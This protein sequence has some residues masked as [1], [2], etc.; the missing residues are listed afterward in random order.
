MADMS[1]LGIVS[2][3]G[4]VAL[5][6]LV[7]RALTP[8][9]LTLLAIGSAWGRACRSACCCS[10]ICTSWRCCFGLSLIGIAVDYS[11]YY[12]VEMF[13]PGERTPRQRLFG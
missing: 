3:I 6:L 11:L 2:S 1:I 4:T 13:A 8:L 5:I 12:C 10:A 9:L 7:F